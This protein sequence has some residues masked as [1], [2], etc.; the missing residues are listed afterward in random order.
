MLAP[1]TAFH[2][3]RLDGKRRAAR[4]YTTDTN[5]PLPSLED[6]PLFILSYLK[7]NPL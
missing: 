7:A 2:E 5:C 3:S 6:R 1:A 4:R